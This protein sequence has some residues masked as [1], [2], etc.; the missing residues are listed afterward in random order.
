MY[1]LLP[2][3]GGEEPAE[4][5]AGS[6]EKEEED[7]HRGE[8]DDP[9]SRWK[10]RIEGETQ[11]MW[12]AVE[13]GGPECAALQLCCVA[14]WKAVR[15]PT[16]GCLSRQVR[17]RFATLLQR[18]R[19]PPLHLPGVRCES[20][21][22]QPIVT[23]RSSRR[24]ADSHAAAGC[25]TR[26]AVSRTILCARA[27]ASLPEPSSCAQGTSTRWALWSGTRQ[28]RSPSRLRSAAS[29][30]AASPDLSSVTTDQCLRSCLVGFR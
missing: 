28:R 30:R 24:F 7:V 29:S 27:S 20:C 3:A 19:M 10:R 12:A 21:L 1:L 22:I 4:G 16:R 8:G 14:V 25:S 11:R 18:E 5:G 13:S 23:H 26:S 6:E 17:E 15:S 2:G 9:S